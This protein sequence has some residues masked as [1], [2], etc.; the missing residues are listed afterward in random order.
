MKLSAPLFVLI[1][2]VLISGCVFHKHKPAA[3][4]P[5][6]SALIITPDASLAAKVVSVNESGRFVVLSFPIRQM[7]KADQVLFLYRG[8]LKAGEV[9]ITGP[10]RDNNIVA[11][12]ISGNAQAGDEV[13]DR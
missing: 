2:G 11:D 8:G 7:P 4:A 3:P 9:K 12:L 13:R 10:Q 1:A 6:G 5:A